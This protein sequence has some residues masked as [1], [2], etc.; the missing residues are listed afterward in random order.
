MVQEI[1]I[2]ICAWCPDA[3]SNVCGVDIR[4]IVLNEIEQSTIL[5]YIF[6]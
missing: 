5:H 1:G 4:S 2:L 3:A 6:K